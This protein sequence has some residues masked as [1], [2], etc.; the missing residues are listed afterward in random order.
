MP[1]KAD[2]GPKLERL[3]KV[4]AAAGVASR[5]RCEEL[6]AEGRVTVNGAPVT[7]PGV[8]VNPNTAVI[9]VNGRPVETAVRLEY[10]AL[11]K[12]PGV[13]SAAAD[14]RGRTTVVD[15]VKGTRHRVAPV[16]RLDLDAE[17]LILLTNDGELANRLLH[18]RYGVLKE[19]RVLVHG[20]PDAAALEA[21]R[22]GALVEGRW[23]APRAVEVEGPDRAQPGQRTWLRMTLAEGR[24]REIKVICSAAGHPVARLVRVRFGPI[25]LGRLH[26]GEHR[27]LTS[28]EVESLRRTA[29]MA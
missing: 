6:I 9:T 29:G 25:A 24:K 18:P 17:G 26:L 1:T 20:A 27:P 8:Q 4:L 3:Q 28:A 11:N 14:A 23:A 22:K 15:L 5:R 2:A 13:L 12:P 21:I 16:G 7:Q 10:W 19:Y